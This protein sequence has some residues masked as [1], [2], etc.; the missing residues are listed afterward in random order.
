MVVILKG[1]CEMRVER[2]YRYKSRNKQD[3][4]INDAIPEIFSQH[5]SSRVLFQAVQPLLS[6]SS[7]VKLIVDKYSKRFRE[8][9]GAVA[10]A[11]LCQDRL[12]VSARRSTACSKI[13]FNLSRPDRDH[14]V[15]KRLDNA[16]CD[17]II[18][19]N[20]CD[21]PHIAQTALLHHHGTFKSIEYA[22]PTLYLRRPWVWSRISLPRAPFGPRI[23]ILAIFAY[24]GRFEV[25]T[26]KFSMKGFAKYSKLGN[27]LDLVESCCAG[28]DWD[29]GVARA[30]LR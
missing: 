5:S 8:N 22:A 9:N 1:A 26:L 3:I 17:D 4:S 10:Y 15:R 29:L 14:T 6:C 30:A 24:R 23:V 19:R 21:R 16:P 27:C 11:K 25:Q 18:R 12:F 13:R 20:S 7:T 28:S 2:T